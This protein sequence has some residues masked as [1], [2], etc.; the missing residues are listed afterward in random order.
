M[1]PILHRV[2]CPECERRVIGEIASGLAR[3]KCPDC[4]RRI[5]VGCNGNETR[6]LMID[7]PPAKVLAS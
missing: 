2:T 1:T 3:F 5:W 4:G 7:R 6:V